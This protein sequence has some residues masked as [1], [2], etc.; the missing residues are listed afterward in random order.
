MQR[1]GH[2]LTFIGLRDVQGAIEAEGVPYTPI[3]EHTHPRGEVPLFRKRLSELKGVAAM[4]LSL[5][6]VERMN[7]SFFTE[8]PAIL[9]RLGADGLIADQAE[10]SAG[11]IA[12]HL[13]LPWVTICNGL[14]INRELAIPPYFT[15]WRY[16]NDFIRRIR[17]RIGYAAFDFVTAS[18]SKGVARR[19]E[20]W[21]LPRYRHV[22]EANSPLLQIAQTPAE[23]DFPRLQL[24]DHFHYTGPFRRT[25]YGAVNFPWDAL[26]TPPLVF[27]SMGT[28]LRPPFQVIAQ[29]CHILKAQLVLSVGKGATLE[30]ASNLPGSP[31]VVEFAPQIELLKR[32]DLFIT[33]AG[34]NSV[35]EALLEGVPAVAIPM[36]GDQPGVAS[37]LKWAGA[38][39]VIHHRDL[40]D[41][42]LQSA[43][44]RVLGDP[45]YR[46]N[47]GR[48]QQAFKASGGVRL[49]GDLILE[50]LSTREPVP[51]KRPVDRVQPN[52]ARHYRE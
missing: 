21:G 18:I 46:A 41:A 39:E 51:R 48:L 23:F 43:I 6:A 28:W 45:M 19:R 32:V 12:E 15:P 29:A 9:S 38:G 4:R 22:D 30:E 35:Q 40:T 33:H 2:A 34:L 49:A 26:R 36:T 10:P 27:A 8:L 37:R 13:N 47:A 7:E 11:T 20:L 3:G 31:I 44:E 42:R 16:R 17:N 1:R 14:P 5:G 52:A 50:A 25:T 24:P